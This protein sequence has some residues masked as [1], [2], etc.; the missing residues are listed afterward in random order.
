VEIGAAIVYKRIQDVR[1]VWEMATAHLEW[2]MDTTTYNAVVQ[3]W[4]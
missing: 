3:A 4:R 1:L 2:D